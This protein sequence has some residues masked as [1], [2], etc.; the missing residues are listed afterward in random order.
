M[1]PVLVRLA[2]QAIVAALA[3]GLVHALKTVVRDH[4]GPLDVIE[5]YSDGALADPWG[6]PWQVNDGVF[7]SAGANK[8]GERGAGD[9]IVIRYPASHWTR[10]TLGQ[11]RLLSAGEVIA[12]AYSH[13]TKIALAI[14]VAFVV[15]VSAVVLLPVGRRC[16]W[17]VRLAGVGPGAALSGDIAFA[18][19]SSVVTT[20]PMPFLVAP[21]YVAA[22][23]VVAF[24]VVAF[25]A[26]VLFCGAAHHS[27]THG[28]SR[29]EL[30][31]G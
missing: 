23:S 8:K 26:G 29:A 10:L 18:V 7:I 14:A 30:A 20:A 27:P 12:S 15:G 13:A 21:G 4:P 22:F 5:F 1:R 28:Q 25:A 17:W 9:D 19:A 16:A 6:T 2:F 11:W 24:Y 3:V 31:A